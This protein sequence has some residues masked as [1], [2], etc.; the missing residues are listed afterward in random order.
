VYLVFCGNLSAFDWNGDVYDMPRWQVSDVHRRCIGDKLL[1]LSSRILC[2][3]VGILHMQQLPI[4][5][6]PSIFGLNYLFIV[7]CWQVLCNHG[8]LSTHWTMFNWP[9]CSIVCF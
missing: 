3:T 6:F 5:L 4:G 7:L 8:A 2:S 1:E 9:L